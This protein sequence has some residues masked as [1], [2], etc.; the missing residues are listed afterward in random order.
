MDYKMVVLDLDDTLLLN[1]G[2][3][4]EENKNT[5]KLAQEKGVKIV[6]ASGRPTFA[7]RQI[8][9]ELELHKYNGY[10]LS[11][12]GAKIIDCNSC[13]VLYEFN[14][15]KEQ[16]KWLYELAL[17]HDVF[18]HTYMDNYIITPHDNPYTYIESEIT[19]MKI[20]TCSNFID[21]LPNNLI[22]AI[23]LQSP[24]YLKEVEKKLKPII[25]NKLYMTITK[26]YFLEFM[27]KDVDKSRSIIRLC[28]KIKINIEDIIAIGDS[29]NDIS[30]IKLAGLGISM[31]NAI[32]EVKNASDFITDT[33][34]NNG[35][36]KAIEKFILNK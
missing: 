2:K 32:E 4:S 10:I 20:K 6:L 15:T 14:I 36:S 33:N 7:I 22:K 17:D 21:S 19:G 30:M 26:P 35:V 16:I 34:E 1:N 13:D 18:I 23:M 31:G 25:S 29:Y 12:N 8:V 9:E 27:N 28:N 5:L 11:Y 24:E 3:I